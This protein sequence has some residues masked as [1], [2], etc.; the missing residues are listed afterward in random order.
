MRSFIA[1]AIFAVGI[2]STGCIS[3]SVR[4]SSPERP[5][6]Q[7]KVTPPPVRQQEEKKIRQAENDEDF[8]ALLETLSETLPEPESREAIL[9]KTVTA[10]LGTPYRYG[11]MSRAGI[12]CSGFVWV[13]YRELGDYSLPRSSE[14]MQRTGTR[15]APARLRKG[16]LLL[17]RYQGKRAD[18]VGIYL[19]DDSFVHASSKLGVVKSSLNDDYYRSRFIEARR[20]LP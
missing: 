8:G 19:G 9:D 16:D 7:K 1:V 13:V 3:S 6:P 10:W 5:V 20:I 11:G 4:F 12:D 14:Q 17:F 18:H 15:V 2:S